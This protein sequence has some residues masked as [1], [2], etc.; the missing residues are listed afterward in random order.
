MVAVPPAGWTVMCTGRGSDDPV[1]RSSLSTTA[2]PNSRSV[3]GRS[4]RAS[5]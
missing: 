2:G 3:I 4:A 1:A 5:R